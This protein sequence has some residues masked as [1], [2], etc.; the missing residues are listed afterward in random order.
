MRSICWMIGCWVLGASSLLGAPKNVVLFVT[1]DQSPDF[2]AYGNPVLKTPHLDALAADGTLFKNAFCTTA[3]CSASR[4]VILSGLHNHA[5]GQYGHQHHFHKFSSYDNIISLPVY[6]EAAGYRTARCGKYHVAP[7]KVY[8][9]G[10]KIPGNSRSPV[11]MAN[12]SKAFIAEE[13]DKPFFLYICTSDPHRGGGT[14]T[15]LPHKPNRFG[16]PRPGK[17]YPGITE[18]KY[19]PK[20]VIVPGFLPDTPTCRA[21]LAQYYQSCS[22]IDQGIGQL[23]KVLKE[24]GQ[25]DNTLFI[26]IAD[27]GIAMPGAKT[28]VYEGGMRAPALVRNPYNKS[29]GLK[30]D[31][32]ISWVDLAPTILDFAGAMADGKVKASVL[33]KVPSARNRTG[34]PDPQTTRAT[35]GGTFHGRSFLPTLDKTSTPGWDVVYASHTF[36][37]IQMYYP[38]RVVRQRRYKLIWNIAHG[39]PFPFAS[40]LWAAPTWQAQWKLGK[41]APYGKKTVHSYIHRPKFELYDINSDPHEGR[42]LAADPDHK[43]ILDKLKS[44]MKAFQSKTHDPWILKWRY[45]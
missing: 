37:E 45:E 4:S 29:R 20:D 18:V 5:N 2:G 24:A 32:M 23:V 25:W 13:S 30:T 44:E 39:Q 28:T 42:N 26:F 21:E 22:R 11:E 33:K 8:Q 34:R 31:A 36:H 9:F 38:M 41:D 7:E 19:D 3:S 43:E 16:N 17:S 35:K 10:V 1:D 27:H 12:N 15:E 6:L 14:A 40:D